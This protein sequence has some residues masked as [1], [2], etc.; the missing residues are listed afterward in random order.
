MKKIL[1]LIG[2]VP[3]CLSAQLV[4]TPNSNTWQIANFL[5]G[6]GVTISNC[7]YVGDANAI[8]IFS[9]TNTALGMNQGLIMASGDVVNAVG[10]NNSTGEGND[11]GAPGDADLDSL[12]SVPTFNAAVL[13][14]DC[15]P[16]DDTMF[17]N[18]LFGSE[19]FPEYVGSSFNDVFAIYIS[20]PGIPFQNMALLPNSATPVCIDSV[21]NGYNNSGPCL[22]CAYYIDNTG[23]PYLQYDGTTTNIV[24]TMQV[25]PD[26]VYHFK[27]AV[28]DAGDGI[29]DSGVLLEAG[30]F[31]CMNPNGV[32]TTVVQQ[33]FISNIY[34]VP[35]TT[36]ANIE[37]TK[38]AGKSAVI[39]VRSVNGVEILSR[40]VVIGADGKYSLDISSLDAGM[41]VMEITSGGMKES[42][43][44]PVS[45]R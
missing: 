36:S 17:F 3:L 2:L 5:T 4:V 28:A 21:N 38:L 1:L 39:K 27:I 13:E 8:G 34:P 20:G 18:F 22:N 19:E 43:L 37:M 26:S 29:Y 42:R 32:N 44:L 15:V 16:T 23:D 25:W 45:S 35:A 14:F 11:N 41:Y 7:T 40:N 24:A 33:H 6:S 31:R 10:P 12:T 30:S 9:A